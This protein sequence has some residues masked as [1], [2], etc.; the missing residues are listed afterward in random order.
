MLFAQRGRGPAVDGP[1]GLPPNTGGLPAGRRRAALLLSF[2]GLPLLTAA[3]LNVRGQLGLDSVLLIYLL[4]VVGIAVTGGLAP[5]LVGAVASCLLANWFLTPPYYT[6]AVQ[7]RDRAVQLLVF[8]VIAVAVSVTVEVGAR[9]RVSAE[10]NRMEARLFARLTSSDIG[11]AAPEAVLD[12]IR[13]LFELDGVELAD[14]AR[15]EDGTALVAVG[16]HHGGEPALT[17]RTDSDLVVR[18]YG[19]QRFAED[20]R[21]LRT[22]AETAARSWEEQRLAE[23]AARAAQLAETDRVRAALLAAVGHDLRTPLAGIKAAVSTL[24]QDDIT[25]TAEDTA[26]LLKS[27][28]DSTDRLTDVITNLLAMTRI[29]AGAVTVALQPVALEEVVGRA[30]LHVGTAN[31]ELDIPEDLPL[32]QADPG[33]LERVVAN[34]LTN[35]ARY[36]PPGSAVLVRGRTTTGRC[37][38]DLEVVD[39]GPGVPPEQHDEMFLPFQRLGDHDHRTG[40]GLGLAIARGFSEAMNAS[41]TPLE[42]PDG[43]LTMRLRLPVAS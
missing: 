11:A 36:S 42:T 6:F 41:L 34:L 31:T 24:R 33:L 12:Q 16:R 43:G 19:P 3:L 9:N 40:V 32:V 37:G 28:E 17:V 39:H 14:P 18:G 26:E 25:W 7:G 2:I 13:Q 35:A 38:V 1:S 27:I 10:R 22:L 5:A 30:V 4:A 29:E 23:E 20:S 8:V 21:L 15:A